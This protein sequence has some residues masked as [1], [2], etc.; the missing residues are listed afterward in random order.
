MD[1]SSFTELKTVQRPLVK[2][3]S[4][5][6]WNVVPTDEALV[7]RAGETGLFFRDVLVR[8]LIAL[9]ADFMT[10]D[11][12]DRVTKEL[13]NVRSSI[14]GNE[15][16]LLWIRGERSVYVPEEQRE[17]NVRFVDFSDP[18]SNVFHVTEEWTYSNGAERNRA[19]V[20]CLING[21]PIIIVEAKAAHRPDGIDEGF[22]QIK[23]YHEETPELVTAPQLF[24]VTHL[25]DFY[26]GVTWGLARRN[27]FNWKDEE[28]GN[29]EAKV[30]TFFGRPRLLGVLRDYIAFIHKDDCVSKVVLRQHQTR[31]IEKVVARAA[32]PMLKRGLVWH[33][34]G[35]GKTLTM[36]SVASQLLTRPEFGKPLVLMLVDRNELESQLFSNLAAYGIDNVETIQSKRHLDRLLRSGYRG[37]VVSM[38]HKFDRADKDLNADQD[39]VVLVDEAHRST[40]GDFGNYLM[41]ALPNATY[42]GFT[43]TP[44][45]KTAH[46]AGTF[47]VF[48]RDDEEGYLDKYSIGESIGDGTT[49]PLS[50]SLA[51][52]QMRVPRDQLEAEFL[53]MTE[54][55]G[56]ADIEELNRILDKAVNL[57]TFLK[58]T[59][60]VE[61]VAAFVANHF[62]ENVAPLGYKA[63]LVGVD[64]EACALYK[65]A[66]DEHLDPHRSKVVY[67][68]SHNDPKE[69]KRFYSSEDEEKQLRKDFLDPEKN[70]QILIVTEKLLTGFDAPILYCMY[71]DKPMR[72]HTLLQAI[73]RVNRPYE[74]ASE[75][76]KPVGFV[77]DFVGIFEKL[78]TA[79]AFDSDVVEGMVHNVDVLKERFESL[80]REDAPGYL[81]LTQGPM[82]DKAV[83]R[84]V[85]RFMDKQARE[86][87]EAMFGELERLYEVISPDA[88]LRDFIDDYLVLAQIHRIVLSAFG[89][90][91]MLV[92]ELMKKTER[93]VR[94]RVGAEGLTEVLPVREINEETLKLI[95]GGDDSKPGA[96]INLAKSLSKAVKEN[97]EEQPYLIPIAAR[98]DAILDN[99]DDRQL[100]TKE[101][102]KELEKAVSEYLEAQKLREQLDLD[103]ATF[104]IYWTI[105][106][107]GVDDPSGLAALIA[108]DFEQFPN[109]TVNADGR[110][111][112]R[113]R[114]YKRLLPA[115]GDDMAL[116]LVAALMTVHPS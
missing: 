108:R 21:L 87:F 48:G 83:E 35:S 40:G 76:R 16:M 22:T 51:P 92:K 13:E 37:L 113:L 72:D 86:K 3:A 111:R 57:K 95:Q 27:V 8:Q 47:K 85:E 103:L 70:P 93:L 18:D 59:D 64:R 71:L 91:T 110:R 79:L 39:V 80:M 38:I 102:L 46:G 49:L 17:R 31:A 104:A 84:V 68:Q 78:E 52:N 112:M 20:V 45:D 100:T 32:D 82:D 42:I 65:S 36:I 56:I 43:G 12:A 114:L 44:I 1:K 4:E 54:E 61:K 30:K 25:L 77:V 115:A 19:D 109:W 89:R 34:Q 88:F 11:L 69:L 63:F 97:A 101:A 9:N 5:V 116:S 98:A 41:A 2:Y 66:L 94:D 107:A 81:R 26:Y 24:D 90:R 105:R 75:V 67:T 62:E 73:S 53:A 60:R 14:E 99:F 33:T 6:G 50:Y 28:P 74:D 23:R 106:Q 55:E 58:S 96:V 10:D 15:E 29:F 7:N